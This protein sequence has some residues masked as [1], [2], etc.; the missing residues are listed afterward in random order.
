[1][2]RIAKH[3]QSRGRYSHQARLLAGMTEMASELQLRNLGIAVSSDSEENVHLHMLIVRGG[4]HTTSSIIPRGEELA[5][6]SCVE[7]NMSRIE[8]MVFVD[9]LQRSR[10]CFEPRTLSSDS[11]QM[12]VK[13]EA[14]NTG[15]AVRQVQTDSQNRVTGRC[16][17]E[18]V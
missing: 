8:L 3:E 14:T 15:L 1:M 13:V 4:R 7:I 12:S 17:D 9:S 18:K 5:P 10:A 2:N 11:E 16:T 6:P